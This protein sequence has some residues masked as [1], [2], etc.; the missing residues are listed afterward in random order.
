[1]RVLLVWLTPLTLLVLATH[2]ADFP[3]QTSQWPQWRGIHRDGISPDT[4]LAQQWSPDGPPLTWKTSGLGP[5]YSSISICDGRI[6][7]MGKRD[8]QECVIALNL[9]DGHE[10]W[11]TPVGR[12]G[13]NGGYPGPRAHTTTD[14]N[15]VYVWARAAISFAARPPLEKR[16]GERI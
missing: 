2:G 11:S 8:G 16:S 3:S 1:M 15:R 14:E 5:G 4:G 10:L 9:N 12:T 13:D 6:F 7:T